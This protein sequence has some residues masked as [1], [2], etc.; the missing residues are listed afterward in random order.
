MGYL[1]VFVNV[2]SA[3]K[4][5][6]NCGNFKVDDGEEC[7]EVPTN[8]NVSC[9]DRITCKLQPGAVCRLPTHLFINV[10]CFV[11]WCDFWTL[12][13]YTFSCLCRFCIYTH[14]HPFNGPLSGT[15]QVSRY[16]K[17]KTN[18]D[19]TGARDGEW[20]WPNQQRQST[21]PVFTA[22]CYASAVLAMGLCPSVSVSVCHMPV[23][24]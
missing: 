13:L 8:V 18:L 12:F 1:L 22:R 4:L 9:C 15:T 5:R 11:L 20:Q 6:K 17:G 10:I 19:F 2:L 7:D 16:Q 14:T 3:E 23:F 24:Y 21:E